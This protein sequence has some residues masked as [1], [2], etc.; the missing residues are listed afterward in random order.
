MTDPERSR[1][2]QYVAPGIAVL[3]ALLLVAVLAVL[4]TYIS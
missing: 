4:I 1:W 3:L 2:S